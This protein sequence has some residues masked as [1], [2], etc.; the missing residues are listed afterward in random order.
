MNQKVSASTHNAKLYFTTCHCEKNVNFTIVD[1]LHLS[2]IYE[3]SNFSTFFTRVLVDATC[4]RRSATLRAKLLL[5]FIGKQYFDAF[6]DQSLGPR[7]SPYP[8]IWG[9]KKDLRPRQPA[10]PNLT[11]KHHVY[12]YMSKLHVIMYM[13]VPKALHK[14]CTYYFMCVLRKTF[15]HVSNCTCF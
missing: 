8:K 10:S 9:S 11:K 7:W 12:T 5:Y 13:L 14:V 4:E 2:H 6:W 1:I 3:F 15:D